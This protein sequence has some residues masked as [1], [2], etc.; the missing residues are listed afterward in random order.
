[1]IRMML[2]LAAQ[3]HA[4]AQHAGDPDAVRRIMLEWCGI[5]WYVV[6]FVS[7]LIWEGRHRRWLERRY[8][9]RRAAFFPP[10]LPGLLL[11]VT[12]P[13]LAL[14]GFMT[15]R[16][17]EARSRS[18]VRGRAAESRTYV[19]PQHLLDEDEQAEQEQRPIRVAR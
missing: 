9:P 16:E 6:G 18:Q 17:R 8:V 19:P 14:V 15:E 7:Y 3:Q 4:P 2:E 10:V 1:M 5:A 12:G 13:L 11:A